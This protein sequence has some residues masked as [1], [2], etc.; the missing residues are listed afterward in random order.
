MKTL[1]K[2]KKNNFGN[3]ANTIKDKNKKIKEAETNQKKLADRLAEVEKLL[4]ENKEGSADKNKQLSAQLLSKTKEAKKNADEVKKVEKRANDL[5]ESVKLKNKKISELENSITRLT[6]MQGQSKEIID[7]LKPETADIKKK[8]DD[9]QENAKKCRF[10]NTGLCRNKT[11]CAEFHP[12]K[13]CQAHSKLGSCSAES[14]CEHRHPHG[15]FFEWERHGGCSNGEGCR[16]RHPFELSRQVS[17]NQ[18]PFLGRGSP[19]RDQGCAGGEREGWGHQGGRW[20]P[21]QIRHHD[22]RGQR[23]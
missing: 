9:K 8:H 3:N 21:S 11:N 19:R 4:D 22:Q 17:G 5:M 10:E 16:N 2:E 23:W 7:K 1:I 20:S 18:E 12:K 6:L 15:I 13:T 14:S